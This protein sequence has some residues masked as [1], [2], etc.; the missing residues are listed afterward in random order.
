[1]CIQHNTQQILL[2]Q[3]SLPITQNCCSNISINFYKPEIHSLACHHCLADRCILLGW[4]VSIAWRHVSIAWGHVSIAWG[5]MSIAWW[6]V[7]IAWRHVSIAWG[8]MYIAW[9]H[10][11]IAWGQMSIAWGQV[12][13][14]YIYRI[15]TFRILNCDLIDYKNNYLVPTKTRSTMT[16]P[17]YTEATYYTQDRVPS[18]NAMCCTGAVHIIENNVYTAEITMNE[19]LE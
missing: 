6:Q 17:V 11:S 10:V 7:Y 4:Q 9:R 12:S 5:Q 16:N 14:A 8:Q 15:C 1:M 2:K 19:M 3:H 13:I 18:W